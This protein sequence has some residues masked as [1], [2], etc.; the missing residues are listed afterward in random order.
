METTISEKKL[1]IASYT[2]T[3]LV[4]NTYHSK[5][6]FW[7]VALTPTTKKRNVRKDVDWL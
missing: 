2:Q 3:Q 1:H 7:V 5:Q 6:L 4:L